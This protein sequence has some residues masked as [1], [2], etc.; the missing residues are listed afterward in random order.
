MPRSTPRRP[1]L[2]AGGSHSGGV[3]LTVSTATALNTYVVVACADGA[4][5]V[6]ETDETNDCTASS[7][8]VTITP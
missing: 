1:G 8:T 3:T 2:A 7:T 6:P 4:G 5:A